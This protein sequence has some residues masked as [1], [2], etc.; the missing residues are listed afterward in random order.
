MAQVLP[1]KGDLGE[2]IGGGERVP[3]AGTGLLNK[4][5]ELLGNTEVTR[6]GEMARSGP[7]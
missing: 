3:D 5:S 7:R 2:I 1:A 6:A 4:S